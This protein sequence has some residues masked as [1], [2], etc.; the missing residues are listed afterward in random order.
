M[1]E[2]LTTSDIKQFITITKIIPIL[3]GIVH[4]INCIIAYFYCNDIPLNYI[5]GISF[6]IIIYLYKASYV[7]KLCSYYRMFLHYSVAI[8]VINVIDVYIGI[9][10]SD[11]NYFIL[12]CTITLFSLLLIIYLKFLK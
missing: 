4:F 7:F 11:T 2:K 8:D 1:V 10:L 3:I 6:I 12:L 9:P 5:G